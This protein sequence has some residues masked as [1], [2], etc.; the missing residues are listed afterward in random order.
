MSPKLTLKSNGRCQPLKNGVDP[1]KL[2]GRNWGTL[3]FLLLSSHLAVV[4]N[5]V[6]GS[7]FGWDW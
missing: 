4:V 3:V 6:V 2:V 7:Q 5:T 1:S